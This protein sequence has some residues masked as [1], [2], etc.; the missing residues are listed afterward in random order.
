LIYVDE[1]GTVLSKAQFLAHA[2]EAGANAQSLVTQG[3]TVHAYGD[4]VV[5]AG[6]YRVRGVLRGK[7]YQR[8]GRFIDT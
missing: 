5:V 3:M 8:E 2:K 1:G 7:P 4:T 6:N